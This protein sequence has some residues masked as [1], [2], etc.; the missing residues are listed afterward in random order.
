[1]A[2]L[3]LA[4][5][6]ALLVETLTGVIL[7][8]FAHGLTPKGSAWAAA[9]FEFL[10][11]HDLLVVQD[12]S[13]Q[14]DVHVW[15]GYL[16]TWTLALKA[17]QSWPTLTG[18]FPRRFSPSRLRA[19]KAAA[20]ALLVLG[21]ASYLSGVAVALRWFPLQDRLALNVH[22]WVSVALVAPLAWH[23]WRYF[24]EGIR[25]LS[26]QLRRSGP[27]ARAGGR[28]ARIAGT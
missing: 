19:E 5:L 16:T 11:A 2:D 21:P 25:V 6:P 12:I 14:T 4:L 3:G 28:A 9:V 26:V 27:G 23:V 24:P 18:W 17:W 7:F 8:L 22:L 10:A 15:A 13:F 1:M 20:W